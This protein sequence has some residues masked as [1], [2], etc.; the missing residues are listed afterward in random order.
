MI[1]RVDYDSQKDVMRRF[2][3]TDRSTLI[4]FKGSTE[5]GRLHAVTDAREIRALLDKGF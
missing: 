1:F 5:T 3:A 4:V 2:K